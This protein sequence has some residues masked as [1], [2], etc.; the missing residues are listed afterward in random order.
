VLGATKRCRRRCLGVLATSIWLAV[1]ALPPGAAS[2]AGSPLATA[3]RGAPV[4]A[5][6]PPGAWAIVPTPD[7]SGDWGSGAL[8]ALH[9]VSCAS[10]TFCMAAGS[11]VPRPQQP[12]VYR[13]Y[14]LFE[15]WDG[16]T[17]SVLASPTGGGISGISCSS[18]HFC[19]AV[20]V[21]NIHN[22]GSHLGEFSLAEVWRGVRWSV[23]AS[24]PPPPGVPAYEVQLGSVA[25]TSRNSCVAVGSYGEVR[26]PR[27]QTLIESWDGAR[28]SLNHSPSPGG[29]PGG[30]NVL[31]AVS[32]T[33]A[34]GAICAAVGYEAAST[35]GH[36]HAIVEVDHHGTW[37]L[38]LAV[39]TATSE[40]S[41]LYGV[42]CS[43]ARA[44]VAV[45]ALVAGT[46]DQLL[47]V[48]WDGHA[49]SVLPARS[50]AVVG[51]AVTCSSEATCAE[52]GPSGEV[53]TLEDGAWTA[54]RT[55]S[56]SGVSARSIS[57]TPSLCMAVGDHVAGAMTQSWAEYR[58]LN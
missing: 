50:S 27:A 20:G 44:C 34:G 30:L 46:T 25:C 1:M 31:T 51:V 26:S 7:P 47:E 22:G 2:A 52:V 42:S 57:C 28:W 12:G 23:A 21:T 53:A 33:A 18:A 11:Y 4:D 17:W 40:S 39:G 16:T 3:T 41:H 29:P 36:A 10:T 45:G 13:S 6:A 35:D 58:R 5:L 19:M 48:N 24:P 14:P 54:A 15:L 49:W 56:Q 37:S 9:A 55:P 32:C 43:L 38:D 8:D